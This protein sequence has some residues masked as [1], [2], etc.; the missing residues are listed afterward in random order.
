[1]FSQYGT[2]YYQIWAIDTN[3]IKNVSL[4]YG[5]TVP[6]NWDIAAD[7][8]CNGLDITNMSVNWLSSSDAG[9]IRADINNDGV[10]NGL[11]VTFI[12]LHW[13]ETWS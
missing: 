3:N 5:F 6:P 7:G 9:W 12:S 1:L 10:V 2:Y 8:I 4:I 13:L 11:D